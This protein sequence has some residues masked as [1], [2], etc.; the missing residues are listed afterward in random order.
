ME[1][2]KAAQSAHVKKVKNKLK[3]IKASLFATSDQN[4]RGVEAIDV[5]LPRY[6]IGAI[7]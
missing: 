1:S 3:E 6:T 2:E 7:R 5:R 4:K